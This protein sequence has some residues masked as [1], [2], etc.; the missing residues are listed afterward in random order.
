MLQ[1]I[2]TCVIHSS[3]INLPFLGWGCSIRIWGYCAYLHKADRLILNIFNQPTN[4]AV[5]LT[6][7]TLAEISIKSWKI[8]KCTFFSLQIK[9]FFDHLIIISRASSH[10]SQNTKKISL[11]ISGHTVMHT[12]RILFFLKPEISRG[13]SD[14]YFETS[15]NKA[16]WKPVG[17]SRRKLF[18]VIWVHWPFNLVCQLIFDWILKGQSSTGICTW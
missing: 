9:Q 1:L 15:S 16:I 17:V 12:R 10:R 7:K 4:K 3:C 5:V 11:L 18:L 6:K 2:F 8:L 13:H 14:R